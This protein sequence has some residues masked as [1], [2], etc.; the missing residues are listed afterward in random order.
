MRTRAHWPATSAVCWAMCS[1][2]G[3]AAHPDRRRR[4][5]AACGRQLRQ[6][7]RPPL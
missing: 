2:H 5:P 7:Q 6:G 3:G 1:G 4:R